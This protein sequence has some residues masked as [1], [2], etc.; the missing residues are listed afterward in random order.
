MRAVTAVAEK[1]QDAVVKFDTYRN[2][3][4]HCAVLPAI[5]RLLLK[6]SVLLPRDATQSADP[7]HSKCVSRL[8]ICLSA[9]L[10][11]VTLFFTQV[12]I[13]SKI[14]SRPNCLSYLLTLI[15]P[16][17]GDL[18][19]KLVWNT[20]TWGQD[21]KKTRNISETVKIGP[22]LLRRSNRKSHTKINDLG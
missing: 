19:Q 1:P 8:S 11:S 18:V 13:T 17:I 6:L 22:R 7:C 2:V 9:R 12:G 16:N 3:Q 4:R 5:A 15:D 10:L 20:G 14:I 21:H